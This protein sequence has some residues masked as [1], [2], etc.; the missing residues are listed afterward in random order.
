M[1]LREVLEL[2]ERLVIKVEELA[3]VVEDLIEVL[4]LQARELELLITH[5]QQVTARLPGFPS[6]VHVM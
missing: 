5:V 2:I 4:H 3:S 6:G 1:A